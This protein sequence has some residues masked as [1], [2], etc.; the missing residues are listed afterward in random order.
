MDIWQEAKERNE[1]FDKAIKEG[2]LSIDPTAN[3]YFGPYMYMGPGKRGDAF[4]HVN[5]RKYLA[6]REQSTLVDILCMTG[7]YK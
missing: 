4:K 2:R 1:A 7:A 3:N 6:P 5:T